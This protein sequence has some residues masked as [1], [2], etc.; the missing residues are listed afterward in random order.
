MEARA[1]ELIADFLCTWLEPDVT[2]AG[3]NCFRRNL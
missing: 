3:L 1:V 2:S